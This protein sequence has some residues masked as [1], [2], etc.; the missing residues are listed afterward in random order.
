MDTL[1][2]IF[3]GGPGFEPVTPKTAPL[4]NTSPREVSWPARRFRHPGGI[5]PVFYFVSPVVPAI[6]RRVKCEKRAPPA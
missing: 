3:N 6:G 2:E 1:N 4:I 5:F